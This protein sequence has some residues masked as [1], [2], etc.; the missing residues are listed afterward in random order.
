MD[1]V[2][3]KVKGRQ[4]DASGEVSCVEMVAEGRHYFRNGKHYVLYND[5]VM[6]G[7]SSPTETIL[8][9]APDSLLLLRKG[10]ICHEQFFA[11]D[12][13][14]SS[15]YKTP[16]GKMQLSVKTDKINIIYGTVSGNIEVD[17]AM[18]IN[19]QWQSQNLLNIEVNIADRDTSRLN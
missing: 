12:K 11:Q 16:Y 18:S 4:T 15:V 9:I 17:Y 8:K 1:K 7:N 10:G 3:V 14:S 13:I 19:G 2:I 5:D 6:S